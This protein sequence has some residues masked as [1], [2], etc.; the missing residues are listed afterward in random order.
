MIWMTLK[1]LRKKDFIIQ[2]VEG[3]GALILQPYIMREVNIVKRVILKN[4]CIE[5][6]KNDLPNLYKLRNG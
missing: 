4:G 3:C 1:K 5:S 6:L 2:D